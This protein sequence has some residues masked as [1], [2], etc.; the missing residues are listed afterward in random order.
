MLTWRSQNEKRDTDMNRIYGLTEWN[1]EYE[2]DYLQWQGHRVKWSR[3]V[4][5]S[6]KM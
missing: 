1:S 2:R 6:E 4:E 5:G 3:N